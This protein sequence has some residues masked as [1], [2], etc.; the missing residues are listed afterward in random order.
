MSKLKDLRGQRFG[1]L[2]AVEYVLCTTRKPRGRWR[3]TCDCGGQTLVRSDC[4]VQGVTRSCGC[5]AREPAPRK[6]GAG[7]PHVVR[8]SAQRVTRNAAIKRVAALVESGGN[9]AW[10]RLAQAWSAPCTKPR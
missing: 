9:H 1:R 5:M 4:L 10:A 3:C 2:V 8:T 7:M 6:Q